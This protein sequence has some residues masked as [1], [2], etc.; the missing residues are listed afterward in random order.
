MGVL[1]EVMPRMR[2]IPWFG[3]FTFHVAFT[4][5]HVPFAD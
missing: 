1:P 3:S 5:A 4:G 2:V